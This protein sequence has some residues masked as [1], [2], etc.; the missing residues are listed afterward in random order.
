MNELKLIKNGVWL[1]L[2]HVYLKEGL[3]CNY[4][5]TKRNRNENMNE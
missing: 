5:G 1:N 4:I 2:T 3:E